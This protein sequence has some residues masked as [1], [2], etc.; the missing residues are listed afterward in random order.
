MD[1]KI[2]KASYEAFLF[3]PVR[4]VIDKIQLAISKLPVRQV[5]NKKIIM[6]YF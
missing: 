3:L 5:L 4:Q 6:T 1:E 2:R